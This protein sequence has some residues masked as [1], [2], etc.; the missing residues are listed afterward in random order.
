MNASKVEEVTNEV[1]EF[2]EFLVGQNRIGISIEQVREIIEPV[3]ATS[4]PHSHPFVKGMIQLR[5]QVFPVIDL[6]KMIGYTGADKTAENKYIVAEFNGKTTVLEV[7]A[8]TQ[9]ERINSEEIETTTEMY[10]GEKVPVL[11]VIKRSDGIILLIDFE[12]A[13]MEEFG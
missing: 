12:T 13:L 3:E 5:G 7:S 2:V 1:F 4:I 11:G 8:V 10:A 6:K 9:I